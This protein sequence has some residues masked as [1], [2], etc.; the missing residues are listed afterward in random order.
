MANTGKLEFPNSEEGNQVIKGDENLKT[1]ITNY[2]K[3]LFGSS[4]Q[5]GISLNENIIHD[6]TQVSAEDNEILSSPFTE[7]EVKEA[8]FEMTCLR[9]FMKAHY[10]SFT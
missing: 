7:K 5:E 9:S 3:R 8:I 1:Y 6:I 4:N 10:P 2:Y